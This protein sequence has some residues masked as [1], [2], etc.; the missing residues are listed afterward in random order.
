M[1]Y[2]S[3]YEPIFGSWYITDELGSGAEGH[4]YRIKRTDALGH[5]YYSALKA[6]AIPPGGEADIESVMAGGLPREEAEAYFRNALEET[7]HEFELLAKLKGNSYIVSYEDHDVFERED[8][9]GWDILMRLEELTP[10]VKSS[11]DKPLSEDDVVSMAT[12]ICRGLSLCHKFGIIHRDIKPDNIFIS[13]AGNYKLGDFGI[14]RIIEQTSSA[15]SRKGTYGYMA[16][17]VYWGR[18]YGKTVDLYSL[19]LVMYRFLND[20]RMPFVPQYPEELKYRDTKNAFIKRMSEAEIPAPRNGSEMLKKI[21][22]KA[23]AYDRSDRYASA[24]EMLSDLESLAAGKTREIAARSGSTGVLTRRG[25]LI[26]LFIIALITAYATY[27]SIPKEITDITGGPAQGTEIYIGESIS[28]E[29]T[30]EP[31]WFSD[32]TVSFSSDNEDVFTVDEHGVISAVAPGEATLTLSAMDYSETVDLNVVPKVTEITGIDKKISM[33]TGDVITLKP[34]LHPEKFSDEEITWSID[35]DK[36]AS[37]SDTGV[38]AAL[39]E[40]KT[41]LKVSAGGT[42]FSATI[43]VSD[44]VIVPTYTYSAPSGSSSKSK[45]KSSGSSGSVK[46]YFDSSDDEHF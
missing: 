30:I 13:P 36:I 44:P 32:E 9:F 17:E 1:N 2:F 39:S 31:S 14:A 45:K 10:L 28:P 41:I 4:L 33:T 35:D 38:V 16:P 11:I 23:C 20:G 3:R 29:Y 43:T 42:S 8:G 46:G 7:T 26:C 21:V 37:V 19:G 27:A 18:K 6:M 34:V 15:M 5:E 22:L 12:D 24:E 40:G 25:T